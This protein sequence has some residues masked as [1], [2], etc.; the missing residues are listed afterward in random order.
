ME[1]EVQFTL[2]ELV[3]IAPAIQDAYLNAQITG[4]QGVVINALATSFNKIVLHL[5][6]C[7]E[8]LKEVEDEIVNDSSYVE[9]NDQNSSLN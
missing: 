5:A 6:D 9:P 8:E 1:T 3:S 7:K 2:L 4:E